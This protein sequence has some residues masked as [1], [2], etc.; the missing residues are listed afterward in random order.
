[1]T[2]VALSIAVLGCSGAGTAADADAVAVAAPDGPV[3]CFEPLSSSSWLCAASFTQQV[4][5]NACR[6]SSTTTQSTCGRYQVWRDQSNPPIAPGHHVCIYDNNQS[7]ALVGGETCGTPDA[8]CTNGCIEYGDVLL[9]HV[10]S[11]G[12]ETDL[13]SPPP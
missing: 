13:C 7:G 4:A 8:T 12:P 9:S 10:M 2:V 11:C 3:P 5:N 6:T 1:L